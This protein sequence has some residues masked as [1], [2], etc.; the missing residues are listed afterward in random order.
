MPVIQAEHVFMG[1]DRHTVPTPPNPA[2][3]AVSLLS[4]Y[5]RIVFEACGKK[6]DEEND[7]EMAMA[8]CAIVDAAQPA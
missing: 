4:G 1:A 3:I 7:L 2:V 6:W 5:F 8:V